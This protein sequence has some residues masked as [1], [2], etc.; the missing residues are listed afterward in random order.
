MQPST[1]VPQFFESD[2]FFPTYQ[3]FSGERWELRV[4]PMA[5]IK[6]YWNDARVITNMAVLMRREGERL[7]TWMSMTPMETE[8][9]EIGCRL[10]TGH[11]VIM[12]MG[13]GW[14]A[15]NSA[16][17]PAVTRVTVVERDPEVIGMIRNTGIFQQL[18]PDTAAKIEVVEGDA[19][20]W[21]PDAPVDTLLADIWLPLNGDDR[22]EQVRRM[23]ANTGAARV[24][25]WGQEMVIAR[26][27]RDTGRVLDDATVA[28][29]VDELGL[30][31]IG[32]EWPDYAA[33]TARAAAHWLRD[34]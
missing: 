26:R 16:T 20:E 10:A 33:L 4:A 18:P 6:G 3:P 27:A 30:P 28:A 9:Q 1:V 15:A 19:L 25:F 7:V 21:V 8:S 11:T 5:I 23:H 13:M 32:P 24:Y 22:V 14:A 31:L 12:G 17:Q 34:T 29:I 2:L